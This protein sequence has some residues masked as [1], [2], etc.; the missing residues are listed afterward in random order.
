MRYLQTT[1]QQLWLPP[2]QASVGQSP[3]MFPSSPLPFGC[4]PSPKSSYPLL[5]ASLLFSPS[6]A[7]S[8]LGFQPSPRWKDLYMLKS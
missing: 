3:F 4:F 8:Q 1:T 7:A 6:T 5:S 2:P